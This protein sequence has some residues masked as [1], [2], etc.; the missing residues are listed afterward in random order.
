MHPHLREAC[1]RDSGVPSF[2]APLAGRRLPPGIGHAY[3][4]SANVSIGRVTQGV[5]L[6]RPSGPRVGP[7]VHLVPLGKHA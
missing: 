5:L 1:I 4:Q 6:Y 7:R 3:D 2:G